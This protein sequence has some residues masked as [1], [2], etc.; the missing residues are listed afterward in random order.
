[1]CIYIYIY[2]LFLFVLGNSCWLSQKTF[3]CGILG[4]FFVFF[5]T[6]VQKCF[7]CS[8]FATGQRRILGG[9]LRYSA[10]KK[11]A[12]WDIWGFASRRES[13]LSCR[14]CRGNFGVQNRIALQGGVA[15]TVTP[16]ALLCATCSDNKLWTPIAQMTPVALEAQKRY[17]SHRTILVA[18]VSQNSFRLVFLG[19]RTI[20]ARYVA[21]LGIARMCQCNTKCQ[22]G[23]NR[24]ILGEC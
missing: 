23:G 3:S 16:V 17:F 8:C 7:A 14:R 6:Q 18:I 9:T 12:L 13:H 19:H 22:G 21:K 15:A 11:E 5:S 4:F 10:F 2:K 1:M 24:T 20:I